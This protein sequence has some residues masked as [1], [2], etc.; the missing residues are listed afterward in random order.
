MKRTRLRVR[1][2]RSATSAVHRAVRST[3]ELGEATLLSG[4]IDP[5]D[6]TELF[7]VAGDERAVRAA[8][9]DRDG[10]RSFEVTTVE[11]GETYVY[12][13]ESERWSNERRRFQELFTA[14]TLVV[15]LPVRYDPDG[16]VEFTVVGASADL[17][18]A[19]ARAN[20]LG[21]V[22]VLSVGDGWTGDPAGGTLTDRQREV[23]RVAADRGYYETP[24]RATQEDVAAE[25]GVA[26]STVA[27]HLR[28]AES[29]LVDAAL[30]A[31]P[32]RE[33]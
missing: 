15:T 33:G 14:G 21:D 1:P 17:R 13:R 9:A 31:S 32:D 4:G 27:E 6:P 12:V 18:N 11:D 23:L 22:T 29:N 3:D 20:D 19:V 30:G 8:L 16:A 10:V 28:K 2:P 7:S 5:D 24:R 25:L 26:P